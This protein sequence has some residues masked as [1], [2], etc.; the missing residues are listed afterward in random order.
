MEIHKETPWVANFISSNLKCHFQ[1]FILLL[2]TKLENR[3]AVQLCKGWEVVPV[4][5]E[6]WWEKG[7]GR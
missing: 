7:V 6:G 1:S 2:S 3:R 5:E 4:E